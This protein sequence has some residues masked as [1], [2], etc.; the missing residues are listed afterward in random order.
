MCM[1]I[2]PRYSHT[3][4][5]I[6]KNALLRV[7][8]CYY[9]H[10]A[11][12]IS[13]IIISI[14]YTIYCVFVHYVPLRPFRQLYI[15]FPYIYP[16]LYIVPVRSSFVHI[17]LPAKYSLF[18]SFIHSQTNVCIQLFPNKCVEIATYTTRSP[19]TAPIS[20]T[21][22]LKTRYKAHSGVLSGLYC[23]CKYTLPLPSKPRT[24]NSPIYCVYYIC[25]NTIYCGFVSFLLFVH[26]AQTTYCG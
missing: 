25:P 2:V 11:I 10:H 20:C 7:R 21:V 5:H 23:K 9:I 12:T 14:L 13:R 6:P 22:Q 18:H 24:R 16:P 17:A 3:Y 19:R 8:V 26:I 1:P 15:V 4:A